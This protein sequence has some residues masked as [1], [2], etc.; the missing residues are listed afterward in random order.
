MADTSCAATTAPTVPVF[1]ARIGHVE[2]PCVDARTLHTQL[3]AGNTFCHWFNARVQKYRL[4][5]GRD[6]APT[7]EPACDAQGLRIG[8]PPK[9]YHFGIETAKALSL[10][11]GTAAAQGIWRQLIGQEANVQSPADTGNDYVR[12]STTQAQTLRNM[13]TELVSKQA[14][15]IS[16]LHRQTVWTA[17]QRYFDITSHQELPASRFEE[18]RTYL[19]NPSLIEALAPHKQPI[20]SQT[21]EVQH[22]INR[23]AWS[24]AAETMPLFQQFLQRY[25]TEHSN[26]RYSANEVAALLQPIQPDDCLSPRYTDR[27]RQASKIVSDT[28]RSTNELFERMQAQLKALVS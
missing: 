7:A 28:Q 16:L 9:N 22:T 13:V 6:Y 10:A 12:I 15:R 19:S 4:Q 2:Q 23:R 17:F 1:L 24:L 11:E 21:T 27:L 5:A 20:I 26:G 3:E 14:H 8:R 25:V 18:A